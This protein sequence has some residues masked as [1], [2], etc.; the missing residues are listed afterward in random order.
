[1]KPTKLEQGFPVLGCDQC[2]GILVSLLYYRDW[3]ER[4]LFDS[5][6]DTKAKKA[7]LD[8]ESIKDTTSALSCP[9]CQKIM[10][11]YKISGCTHNRL[12]LCSTCDEAWLDGGEWELL[13]SLDVQHQMPKV[14]TEAWQS[15]LRK[16]QAEVNRENRLKKVIGD[17][18]TQSVVDF[19]KWLDSHPKR[20]EI[21][22]YLAHKDK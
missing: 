7:E 9:K 1:M 13:E 10:L 3:A 6:T 20:A 5:D 8:K 21:V 17:T 19:K 4:D 18:D 12:D 15:R 14:F 22:F 16:E 2:N 11:K